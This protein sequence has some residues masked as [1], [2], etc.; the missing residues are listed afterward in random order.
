MKKFNIIIFISLFVNV[1][2]VFAQHTLTVE[3][4][5]LR[6]NKGK[7]HYELFDAKQKSIKSG[8]IDIINSKAVIVID[9][10]KSA[11][12]GLNF[13]HDENMNKKLDTKLIGIPKVGFGYSNNALVKFGPPPFE[14]WLFEV[15]TTTK[16]ICKTKYLNF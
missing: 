16:I 8:S 10:L 7:V 9:N 12:Y 14:K 15:N 1:F 2:S 6:N 5:G 13:I 11:K 3:F 4:I